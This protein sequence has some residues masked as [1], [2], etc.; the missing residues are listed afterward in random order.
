MHFSFSVLLS[1]LAA[2]AVVNALPAENLQ[3]GVLS[4]DSFE[5]T[6]DCYMLCR[7]GY[8]FSAISCCGGEQC[9]AGSEL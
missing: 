7:S 9:P 5:F 1:G 6:C 8:F 2:L 3:R 4:K